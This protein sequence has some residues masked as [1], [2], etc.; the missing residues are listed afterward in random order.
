MWTLV[1]NDKTS[2]YKHSAQHQK[3]P[4]NPTWQDADFSSCVPALREHTL[5]EISNPYINQV[6]FKYYSHKCCLFEKMRRLM[7]DIVRKAHAHGPAMPINIHLRL[8]S[9]TSCGSHPPVHA[10]RVQGPCI[11]PARFYNIFSHILVFIPVIHSKALSHLWN[12]T[13][14]QGRATRIHL[15]D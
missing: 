4:R 6:R 10:K 11:A 14:K 8:S 15:S 12:E 3:G 9:V 1:F 7:E 5:T 2:K 13:G